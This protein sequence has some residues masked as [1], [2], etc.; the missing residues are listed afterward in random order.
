M[1]PNYALRQIMLR[2]AYLNDREARGDFD[3]YR[4]ADRDA[5]A[6]ALR[7]LKALH[8][9]AYRWAEASAAPVIERRYPLITKEQS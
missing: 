7:E 3:R 5:L 9:D 8:P 2:L 1:S 6:W 4:E